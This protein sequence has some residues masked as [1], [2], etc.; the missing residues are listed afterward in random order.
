MGADED[1]MTMPTQMNL[2]QSGVEAFRMASKHRN[3]RL[4]AAGLLV[5][6][7]TGCTSHKPAPPPSLFASGGRVPAVPAVR[8]PFTLEAINDPDTGKGAFSFGGHELPP[9]MHVSPGQILTLDYVNHMSPHSAE[10][11]LHGPCM[12]MT[13]LHFHGLH[14]SPN[15]PQD[16]AISMIA[17]PGQSLQ[18]R[19]EIPLDQ[20]PG[21]YWYHT[22][23]HGESYQQSLDGMSGAIVI[24]GI[25]RYVPEVR[26]MKER[27][28]VLRDAEVGPKHPDTAS[29][30]KLV[31]L[32]H[33]RCSTV[34]EAPERIFTVNGRTRPAIPIAPGEKQFWRIV[35]ASPDLYADLSIDSEQLTVVARDG[36]PIAF[37]DP[38]RRTEAAQHVLLPP[39]GRVEAIVTGPKAGTEA[40]LRTACVDTG[41]D[42]DANPA[43]VLAD[44]DT[45][46]GANSPTDP[47]VISQ[48]SAVYKPLSTAVLQRYESR[49]PDYT[50]KFTEDAHGFYINDRAYSPADGPMVTVS[51]GGYQHWHISNDTHELHP[52]HIHQVHFLAY[53]T[54]GKPETVSEWLDTVNVPVGGSVDLVMDFTDPIIRG[55]SLFH[56]HLLKHE[57]KG[58]MA[59]ILF[60]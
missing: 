1:T 21:L 41:A 13:N 9:V 8:S 14:V 48:K 2:L 30:E 26:T 25:D 27:V 47:N 49:P 60:R 43:M 6:V 34:T 16:D 7:L 4:T 36:M 39:A 35:N 55:M 28:L 22:H 10:Q 33:E 57:D 46:M 40:S 11:C 54:N 29:L 32:S 44:L 17:M 23:P 45:R 19:V 42:G 51:V 59:K 12:D 56:C 31:Q 3:R 37:H 18:Y 38:T 53:A 24:D 50:V 20:P 15:S 52:F 5:F 58:M